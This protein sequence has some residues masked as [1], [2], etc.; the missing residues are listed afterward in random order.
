MP[1]NNGIILKW[2]GWTAMRA[3]TNRRENDYTK[4]K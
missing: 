4:N 3:S 2:L 1:S